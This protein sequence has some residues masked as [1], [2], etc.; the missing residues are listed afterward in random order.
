MKVRSVLGHPLEVATAL[1]FL[2][3]LFH[4]GS[5]SGAALILVIVGVVAG[6]V[7]IAYT[8][9]WL[10]GEHEAAMAALRVEM[11]SGAGGSLRNVTAFSIVTAVVAEILWCTSVLIPHPKYGVVTSNPTDWI[12]AHVVAVPAVFA[13]YSHSS[14]RYRVFLTVATFSFVISSLA[15]ASNVS[16]MSTH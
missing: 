5:V 7:L 8:Q 10:S 11:T 13:A 3:V 14:A 1:L 15:I 6:G 16:F 2:C 4:V 12:L 9:I